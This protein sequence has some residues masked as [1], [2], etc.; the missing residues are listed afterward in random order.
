MFNYVFMCS[1]CGNFYNF[2]FIIFISTSFVKEKTRL[3]FK[4][5]SEFKLMKSNLWKDIFELDTSEKVL[6]SSYKYWQ[7]L[8]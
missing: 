4:K 5:R 2:S 8:L 7:G 6:Q 1:K 3:E